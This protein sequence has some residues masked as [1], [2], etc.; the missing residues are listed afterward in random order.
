MS[1]HSW[2]H[3]LSVAGRI[4]RHVTHLGSMKKQKGGDP[5]TEEQA[6]VKFSRRT[7]YHVMLSCTCCN[8]KRIPTY[9]FTMCGILLAGDSYLMMDNGLRY[10]D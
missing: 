1:V 8:L 5:E 2:Q 7:G 9:L 6:V 3:A 10:N 4:G